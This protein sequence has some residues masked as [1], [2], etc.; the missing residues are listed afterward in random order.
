MLFRSTISN[1]AKVPIDKKLCGEK[2]PFSQHSQR[3]ISMVPRIYVY[4][5]PG[6]GYI[7]FLRMAFVRIGQVCNMALYEKNKYCEMKIQFV[8]P[9]AYSTV[10]E[11]GTNRLF[12]CLKYKFERQLFELYK[13][14]SLVI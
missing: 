12:E 7:L 6:A 13:M 4:P 9:N 8:N 10:W 5:L 11:R 3:N 14:L 1:L 2:F